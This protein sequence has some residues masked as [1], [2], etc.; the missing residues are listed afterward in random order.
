L[1][2][3]SMIFLSFSR[4]AVHQKGQIIFSCRLEQTTSLYT[5]QINF[6]IFISTNLVILIHRFYHS[7]TQ[8]SVFFI[9]IIRTL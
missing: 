5:I 2:N 6:Y 1:K 4:Q 7:D 3:G 8:I 9:D